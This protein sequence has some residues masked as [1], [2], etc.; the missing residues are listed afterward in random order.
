M[1]LRRL[2]LIELDG[3]AGGAAQHANKQTQTTHI[4]CSVP[5]IAII[6]LLQ[7]VGDWADE[8]DDVDDDANRPHPIHFASHLG[9][10]SCDDNQYLSLCVSLTQMQPP[11]RSL[12]PQDRPGTGRRVVEMATVVDSYSELFHRMVRLFVALVLCVIIICIGPNPIRWLSLNNVR[13][14]SNL[15][16]TAAHGS[17]AKEVIRSIRIEPFNVTAL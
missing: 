2:V 8:G 13:I 1:T 14:G 11:Y 10:N 7:V 17:F 5:C 3:A 9:F 12:Q 15:P 4:L 16:E 6:Y